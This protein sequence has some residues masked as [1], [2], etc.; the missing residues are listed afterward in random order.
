M[1]LQPFVRFLLLYAVLFFLHSSVILSVSLWWWRTYTLWSL[2]VHSET[3]ANDYSQALHFRE[4]NLT[5]WHHKSHQNVVCVS[6]WELDVQES[7]GAE[8]HREW[9][10]LF[11]QQWNQIDFI[12]VKGFLTEVTGQRVKSLLSQ[13]PPV[14]GMNLTP[15]QP[16]VFD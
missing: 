3:W 2:S 10:F 8:G 6:A 12:W 1:H 4:R 14:S 11:L 9:S 5:L 7:K 16:S 13:V 15:S